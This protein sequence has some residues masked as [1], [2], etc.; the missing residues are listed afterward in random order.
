MGTVALGAVAIDWGRFIRMHLLSFFI[1]TLAAGALPHLHDELMP[2]PV[3]STPLI[4]LYILLT[5]SY[6]LLWRIPNCCNYRPPV[7]GLKTNNLSWSLIP[8]KQLFG[9]IDHAINDV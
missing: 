3:S 4:I 5:I 9:H 7:S 8:Y 1:L 2:E 6:S